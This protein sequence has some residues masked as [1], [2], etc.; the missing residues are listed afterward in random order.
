VDPVADR[1]RRRFGGAG[2]A[3]APVGGRDAGGSLAA[4][5]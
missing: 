4:T 1:L 5:G 3:V 2:A